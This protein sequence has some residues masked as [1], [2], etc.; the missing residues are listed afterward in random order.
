MRDA[1]PASHPVKRR[2]P[3]CGSAR[4]TA[5]VHDLYAA[6]QQTT[7]VRCSITA[8]GIGYLRTGTRSMTIKP[9]GRALTPISTQQVRGKAQASS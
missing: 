4:R 6:S 9:L 1:V 8:A 5:R 3:R 7:R 2:C